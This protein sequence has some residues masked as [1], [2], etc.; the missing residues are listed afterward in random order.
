V[1][2]AQYREKADGA[3]PGTYRFEWSRLSEISPLLQAAIVFAEDPR[4]WAHGGFCWPAVQFALIRLIRSRRIV[5]GGST[6][7]QQLAKNLYL[8]PQRTISRKAREVIITILLER[9]LSKAR[10]L[11]LYLNVIEWGIGVWGCK[12]ACHYYF[13]KRPHEISAFEAAFLVSLVPAPRSV[14]SPARVQWMRRK[15]SRVLI[16]L[17]VFSKIDPREC[18]QAC[19]AAMLLERRLQSGAD[20]LPALQETTVTPLATPEWALPFLEDVIAELKSRR[21]PVSEDLLPRQSYQQSA[22]D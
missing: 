12:N 20:L 17:C 11:E 9:N 22:A 18:V 8:S 4:F 15:Q 14:M 3:V 6:I 19:L 1:S 21:V 5:A 16:G 7:T 10:I 2:F 13:G